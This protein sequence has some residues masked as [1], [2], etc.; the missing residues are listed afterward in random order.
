[1]NRMPMVLTFA[2]L[3]LI[4][5]SF[6][7]NPSFH[8][9]KQADISH[10]NSVDTTSTS[11]VLLF[12]DKL[13]GRS[14]GK[15]TDIR[16]NLDKGGKAAVLST[17]DSSIE[18][19]AGC[20]NSR[21]GRIELDVKFTQELTSS[22]KFWTLLSDVGSGGSHPGAVNIHWR[23]KSN[24]LEFMI[25]DGRAHHTCTSKTNAWKLG[26]WYHLAF[27]YG[28]SGMILEV[29]GKKEDSNPFSQPLSDTSKRIGFHDDHVEAPPVMVANFKT[30]TLYYESVRANPPIFTPNGDGLTDQCVIQYSVA[31]NS[32]VS[33]D[34]IDTKGKVVKKLLNRTSVTQGDHELVW[35]GKNAPAGDY[36]VRVTRESGGK[37]TRV[38]T[39][40]KIDLRWKW[41]N[42]KP[43]LSDFF[44]IGAWYFWED[45]ASY[46]NTH[47]DDPVRA[48]AYYDSTLKELG[49]HEVNLIVADWTPHDHRQMMLDAS[50]RNGVKAILHLDEVNTYI[51]NNTI[52]NGYLLYDIANKAIRD[53]KNHP[54]LAGYYIIDEPWNTPE[55]TEK[56][57]FSK[58]VLEAIDP[59]HPGFSCL[60]N[61]YEETL[62]Q[63]DY[64]VLVVDIYP[65]GKDWKGGD[66]STFASEC[67]RGRKNAGDRPLWVILQS[68]GTRGGWRVPTPTEIE[69]Q[70]W[71]SLAG[72]AKGIIYF[73]YQST[74]NIQ[75]EWIDGWVKMDMTPSDDRLS[76]I[77]KINAKLK[78][79]APL[80][81]KLKSTGSS[82]P[83]LPPSVYGNAFKDASGTQYVI[84]A[85]KSTTTEVSMPWSGS[86]TDV[87]TGEK[88]EG[89]IV[90]AP[91]KGRVL[92][93]AKP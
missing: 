17:P 89:T 43:S 81:L 62:K 93:L 54:A 92:K 40:V 88:L 84:V 19:P 64:P 71:L 4:A 34:V 67:E 11:R 16:F 82:I 80:L 56:I 22:H 14:F 50:Q 63:V 38:L 90:L 55:Q 73:M 24:R 45:D 15:T 18:Y 66:L 41:E 44:P 3:S 75:G 74:T 52:D 53:Y 86:A 8:K 37:K 48:K 57:A 30:Y 25:F 21:S 61:A 77:G 9:S 70:V 87:L 35:D 42:T 69:A 49:E 29:N 2:A 27:Q 20:F 33:I 68:F 6:A 91:G 58:K 1:M 59:K 83:S 60:L 47:V 39:P 36:Q 85:N 5:S 28:Q 72:G 78:T 23:D 46:I 7:T 13:N 12:A 31:S 26:Q 51:A 32:Q 10:L 76:E 79:L 65:I